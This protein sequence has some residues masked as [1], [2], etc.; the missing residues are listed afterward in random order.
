MHVDPD[1]LT[2]TVDPDFD[3]LPGQAW[4]EDVAVWAHEAPVLDIVA[5]STLDPASKEAAVAVLADWIGDGI[6]PADPRGWLATRSNRFA[7]LIQG[8]ADA[9]IPEND[10]ERPTKSLLHALDVDRLRSVLGEYGL[11]NQL[12]DNALDRVDTR[13]D[14]GISAADR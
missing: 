11:N 12:I 8:L 4:D 9:A 10:R 5:S 1:I 6:D 14:P 2:V 3:P 13:D 7:A